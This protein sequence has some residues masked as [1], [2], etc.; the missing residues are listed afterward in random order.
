MNRKIRIEFRNDWKSAYRPRLIGII[1]IVFFPNM[2]ENPSG[3]KYTGI[4]I[5]FL[6]IGIN[7]YSIK[8]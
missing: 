1:E 2:Q 3:Y 4:L 8:A 7:I 6:G 5:R